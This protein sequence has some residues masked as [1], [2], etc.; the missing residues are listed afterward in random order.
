MIAAFSSQVAASRDF[1]HLSRTAAR[2]LDPLISWTLG[3]AG[4][5]GTLGQVPVGSLTKPKESRRDRECPV[6]HLQQPNI[7]GTMSDFHHARS[8]RSVWLVVLCVS[9]Y[10]PYTTICIVLKTTFK[11]KEIHIHIARDTFLSLIFNS[12][13]GSVPQTNRLSDRPGLPAC[14]ANVT[15]TVEPRH[16]PLA[17]K[18]ILREYLTPP[19]PVALSGIIQQAPV[20]I[21]F[22]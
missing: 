16:K 11:V 13:C 22:T 20:V 19:L 18:K 10:F 15:S 21:P 4:R 5:L 12:H 17:T 3:L 8:F 6:T 1:P 2:G 9:S 7:C 14:Q